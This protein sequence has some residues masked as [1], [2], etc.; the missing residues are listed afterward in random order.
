MCQLTD[1]AFRYGV[2][3]DSNLR[4]TREQ[5]L[6]VATAV[7]ADAAPYI[8]VI[9]EVFLHEGQARTSG[10]PGDVAVRTE[11]AI[12]IDLP[13]LQFGAEAPRYEVRGSITV[14][15]GE[16]N[17]KCWLRV[18]RLDALEDDASLQRSFAEAERLGEAA[19]SGLSA[20]YQRTIGAVIGAACELRKAFEISVKTACGDDPRFDECFFDFFAHD[21]AGARPDESVWSEI[22]RS[23]GT[24][25]SRIEHLPR[26]GEPMT[27]E[28]GADRRTI[29]IS[30][31]R[32]SASASDPFETHTVNGVFALTFDDE[33][34]EFVGVGYD[35]YAGVV[36]VKQALSTIVGT[37]IAREYGE[38]F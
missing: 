3:L 18:N 10:T 32:V 6:A 37:Q 17:S 36:P 20:L 33:R 14:C 21:A 31:P 9:S 8:E 35:E 24:I 38:L 19:V 22:E 7:S 12:V 1:P 4:L 2:I 23:I 29:G 5:A 16:R 25:D 27:S 28:G 13:V 11:P 15:V 26:P 30:T 34:A